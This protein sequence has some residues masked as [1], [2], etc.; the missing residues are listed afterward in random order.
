M[1]QATKLM[2]GQRRAML[3]ALLAVR[4]ITRRALRSAIRPDFAQLNRLM[5]YVERFPENVHQPNE[6]RVL[7]SK[8]VA[9]EPSM[10]RTVARLR[11]DHSAMKGYGNR[12]RSTLRFWQQGDPNAGP[13]AASIADDYSHFCMRHMRAERRELLPVAERVL[14]ESQWLDAERAFESAAD[15]L[16][17]SRSERER[18]AALLQLV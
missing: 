18:M 8:V 17:A 1:S 11:R 9:C 10:A 15:P 13:L 16:A 14:T 6:E 12:L 7:F 5:G 2:Q 4:S 3:W